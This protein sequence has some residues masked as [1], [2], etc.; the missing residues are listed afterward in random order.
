MTDKLLAWCHEQQLFCPGDRVTLAVSGGAD[1]MAMLHFLWHHRSIWDLTIT[2]A[3][4]NHQLRGA[5]SDRD[6]AFVR[7]VCAEQGIAFVCGSQDVAAYAKKTGQGL[8]AAARTLRY[9]FLESVDPKAKLATAHTASDNLETVLMHL[10]RGASLQGLCGI[11]PK[12]NNIVRPMLALTR[13]DIVR[14]VQRHGVGFVTD[15][16][17]LEDFCLRNRLRRHVIPLLLEENPNV[18]SLVLG[19]SLRL[20]E[21]AQLLSQTAQAALAAAQRAAVG[22]D[23]LA[24]APLQTQPPAL[25]RR[26]LALWLQSRG[27]QGL[28]AAHLDALA[29][30][31]AS[32]ATCWQCSLPGGS[33]VREYD[34]L[35]YSP[36]KAGQPYGPI[37]LQI[38]GDTHIPGTRWRL[39]CEV[40]KKSAGALNSPYS[41]ALNYDMIKTNS[42]LRSRQ[43]GDVLRQ[44]FGH[45][46]VKRLLIDRKIPQRLR[47]SLPVFVCGGVVCAVVG[48][49]A[50]PAFLAR[51][52][53]CAAHFTLDRE[54]ETL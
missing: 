50:D 22:Q 24:V 12:R 21:D 40:G 29:D 43:S 28:G 49:G 37:P 27:V 52:G 1:S 46:T 53:D 51:P 26:I 45:K 30:L 13:Q 48:I 38:P 44:S 4:F 8:E 31:V 41:F 6:E 47:G 32:G 16:S 3:H 2:C 10:V 20:R 34:A 42:F 33:V 35:L 18:Q 15:S 14:Y 5:E 7:A 23:A 11:A 9:E 17:N 25:L 36:E 54:D 19:Q 39:H